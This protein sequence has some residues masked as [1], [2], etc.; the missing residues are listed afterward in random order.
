MPDSLDPWHMGE[1]ESLNEIDRLLNRALLLAHDRFPGEYG[2]LQYIP[3]RLRYFQ[4][5][6]HHD[7]DPAPKRRGRPK[8]SPSTRERMM[9]EAACAHCGSTDDL[10]IDHVH[11]LSRGGAN[12]PDNLQVLCHDCNQEKGARTMAEMGW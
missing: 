3:E 9:A 5:F 1:G 4:S 6:Y 7:F 2:P 10:E 8:V 12:T 11:P